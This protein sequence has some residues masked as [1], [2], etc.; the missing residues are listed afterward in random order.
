MASRSRRYCLGGQATGVAGQG[1][2]SGDHPVTG[3]HDAQRVRAQSGPDRAGGLR[4]ADR[5][6]PARRTTS[7]SPYAVTVGQRGQHLAAEMAWRG[8]GRPS[9]RPGCVAARPGSRPAPSAPHP[10]PR[11]RAA[12]GA[13][14]ADSRCSRASSAAS[15]ART[16]WLPAARRPGPPATVGRPAVSCSDVGDV[17][18]QLRTVAGPRGSRRRAAGLHA[19]LDA[20]HAVVISSTSW[21]RVASASLT[22]RRVA[23]EVVPMAAATPAWSRSRDVSQR[24]GLALPLGQTSDLLPQS[25]IRFGHRARSA[26]VAGPGRLRQLVD[27][28]RPP[29]SRPMAVHRAA[30]RDGHEPGAQVVRTGQPRVRRQGLGPR[31]LG[32]VVPLARPGEGVGEAGDVAPVRVDELLE[33]REGHAHGTSAGSRAVRASRRPEPGARL[34]QRG[35]PATRRDGRREGAAAGLERPRPAHSDR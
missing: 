17:A 30:G 7:A 4:P 35:A 27:R 23:A 12:P 16:T 18:V 10:G 13:T 21:R 6:W 34:D 28:H 1:A 26:P 15:S 32:D 31:L 29:G 33:R 3:Q 20:T 5:P 2:G 22:S 25:R 9:A 8:P 14:P 11:R 24:D 19:R